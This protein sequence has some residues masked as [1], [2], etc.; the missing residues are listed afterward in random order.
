[1]KK[2][3]EKMMK[4][5]PYFGADKYLTSL[6]D[7]A[8]KNNVKFNKNPSPK[9]AE[10]LFKQKLE[11]VLIRGPIYVDY[12][13]NVHFGKNI[14]INFDCTILDCAIVT[15]GDNA[16]IG[17]N[18]KIYAATH[19]TSPEKRNAE[20]A[21][22]EWIGKPINIEKNC[23][24]GGGTIILDGVTIGEGSTIG[25]GSVVTESIPPNSIAVGNPCKVVKNIIDVKKPQI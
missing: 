19:S 23:W 14:I 25:A 17:P 7:E 6:R 10:K 16:F 5:Q 21:K 24:I 1:M 2:E 18:V 15:I 8:S 9:L 3:F 13:F 20:R 4:G 22:V 12:G 11:S